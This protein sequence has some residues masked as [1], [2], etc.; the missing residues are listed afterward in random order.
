MWFQ[1]SLSTNNTGNMTHHSPTIK[2]NTFDTRNLINHKILIFINLMEIYW[3][4]QTIEVWN[5]VTVLEVIFTIGMNRCINRN[6]HTYTYT[7][8][9]T[10][11]WQHLVL[12]QYKWKK[13]YVKN[14]KARNRET[15]TWMQSFLH[16]HLDPQHPSKNQVRWHRLE[17]SALVMWRETYPGIY[18]LT[19]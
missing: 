17:A 8:A 1:S 9:F 12:R 11:R 6:R 18:W 4:M 13:I 3:I 7:Q 10:H 16:K 5:M 2:I 14:M 19:V 15:A